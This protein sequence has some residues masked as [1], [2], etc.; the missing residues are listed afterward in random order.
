MLFICSEKFYPTQI[1]DHYPS[2]FIGP[3][4]PWM[5]YN[6]IV[7]C[8]EVSTQKH[9]GHLQVWVT[10]NNVA[11]DIAITNSNVIYYTLCV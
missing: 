3:Y 5:S 7:H 2:L 8:I 4:N 1:P 6:R 10:I 11:L 9:L